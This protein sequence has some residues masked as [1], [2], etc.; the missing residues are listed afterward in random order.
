MKDL[1]R[2]QMALLAAP[3]SYTGQF[4]EKVLMYVTESTEL[5]VRKLYA[6]PSPEKLTGVKSMEMSFFDSVPGPDLAYTV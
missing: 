6:L 3:T 2:K 5:A 1:H 4:W